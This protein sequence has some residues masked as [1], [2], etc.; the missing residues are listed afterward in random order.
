MIRKLPITGDDCRGCGA[1]CISDDDDDVYVDLTA[2]DVR[3]FSPAFRRRAV[4]DK[5]ASTEDPW[6]SLRT[7]H[8]ESGNCVCVA[9]RGTIGSRVSCGIY[10]RRPDGCRTFKPGSAACR[11]AR[12]DAELE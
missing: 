1:C 12:R 5:R 8:D 2:D 9:L 10:E 4:V 11:Q 6:M 7:K 3:R